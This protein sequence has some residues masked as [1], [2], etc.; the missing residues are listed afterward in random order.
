MGGL[1]APL[2]SP[3]LLLG[4]TGTGKRL[5]PMPSIIHRR[6]EMGPS[7]GVFVGD[8]RDPS[9]QRALRSREGRLH[10]GCRQKEGRFER[11]NKGT[12][13][14]DEIGEL[15]LQAQIRLLR[16]L[17]NE[18]IERV[19]G[20]SSVRVDIRVISATNR[21]LQEMVASGE[22]R[23]DLWFRLNVFPIAIPPLITKRRYPGPGAPLY[24][25]QI[26]RA[27]TR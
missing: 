15:P 26:D 20:T 1:V 11:A 4:E 17:E 6:E 9:R 22:F 23:E 5:S 2:D 12:I 14:L 21:N 24:R 16:V 10:R 8:P 27:Q 18:E 25:A 19:G 3:V 13:F 7:R